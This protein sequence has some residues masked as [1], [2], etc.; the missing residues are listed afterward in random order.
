MQCT[1]KTS[2]IVGLNDSPPVLT[3]RK[4]TPIIFRHYELLRYILI[5]HCRN[6]QAA[7]IDIGKGRL[8]MEQHLPWVIWKGKGHHHRWWIY[9]SLQG[10]DLLYLKTDASGVGLVAG[11]LQVWGSLCF[12]LDK[13]YDDTAF[14]LIVYIGKMLI[15]TETRYSNIEREALGILYSLEKFNSYCFIFEVSIITGHKPLLSI[16]KKSVITLS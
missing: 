3:K 4:W 14:H 6:M 2:R 5:I 11:F 10:K 16:Y 7:K 12:S 13:A 8:D 9:E 1:D 15:S